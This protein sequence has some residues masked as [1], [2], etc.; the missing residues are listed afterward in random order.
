IEV[1]SCIAVFMASGIFLSADGAYNKRVKAFFLKL[2]TPAPPAAKQ[3]QE[4]MGGLMLLYAMAFF[5]T[6]SLF[7]A[8]SIPSIDTA[9]GKLALGAGL[10]CLMGAWVFYARRTKKKTVVSA[11]AGRQQVNEP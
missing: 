4:I 8:M 2:A 9:S 3:G 6:G 7:V 10:S 11:P 5:V 1:V